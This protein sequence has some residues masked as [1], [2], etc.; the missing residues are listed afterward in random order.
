MPRRSLSRRLFD[1]AVAG[2]CEVGTDF[3]P[4]SLS[5]RALGVIAPARWLTRVDG[6]D[7]ARVVPCRA[8]ARQQA[9]EALLGTLVRTERRTGDARGI[10]PCSPSRRRAT[11][12]PARHVYDAKT[13]CAVDRSQRLAVAREINLRHLLLLGDSLSFRSVRSTST[14]A[15]Y[16]GE[17]ERPGA[18]LAAVHLGAERILV[19]GAG[20][21]H[22]PPGERAPSTEYPNLAQIAGHALSNIFL[23]ALAADVERLRRINATL[24][25]LPPRSRAQTTLKPIEVLVIAPSQRLDDIASKHLTSLPLPIRAMLRGL[26]VSG[27]GDD[28]RGAALAS[29][30]LFESPYTRS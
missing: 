26:G 24:A 30:L 22:E 11:L 1:V 14:A 10:C 2:S 12:G 5:R 3:A 25:L 4:R 27:Q 16:C 19:V 13:T 18:D 15:Q 28:A 7:R 17:V 29:Y 8:R 21:M 9:A 6:G 23:D 20:R